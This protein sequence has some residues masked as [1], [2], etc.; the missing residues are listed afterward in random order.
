MEKKIK[1]FIS[2]EFQN[3]T[4]I[5]FELFIHKNKYENILFFRDNGIGQD[6]C[7]SLNISLPSLVQLHTL[8]LRSNNLLF[9]FKPFFSL[10]VLF[11]CNLN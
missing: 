10:D 1:C 11:F 9:F 7:R 3:F 6:G 5:H 8:N 2:H 4:M